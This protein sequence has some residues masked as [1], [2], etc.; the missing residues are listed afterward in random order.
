MADNKVEIIDGVLTGPSHGGTLRGYI[1]T[2]A[3]Q[4]DLTGTYVPLSGINTLFQRLPVIGELLGGREGEGLIGVTFAVRGPLDKPD[5][6]IN[7][8][9]V[10][11]VGAFRSLFEFRAREE[12]SVAAGRPAQ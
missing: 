12:P 6:L 9:S 5:F 7:P 4:Y 2:D 10:L 3:K 11:A 8:A 1:Y